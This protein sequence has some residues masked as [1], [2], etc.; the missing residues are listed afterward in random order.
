MSRVAVI[1]N[2]HLGALKRAWDSSA[3]TRNPQFDLVFFGAPRRTALALRAVNDVLATE[4]PSVLRAL[5]L[6]SG[7]TD[8]IIRPADYDLIWL[9][10]LIGLNWAVPQAIRLDMHSR[11]GGARLSSSLLRD[12]FSQQYRESALHYLLQQIRAISSV[13][14]FV[15]PQPFLSEDSPYRKAHRGQTSPLAIQYEDRVRA[16]LEA[17][18]LNYLPQ[19][20]LTVVDRC[21]T[22]ACYSQAGERLVDS[23][24]GGIA[25][26]VR[27]MNAD[28]GRIVINDFMRATRALGS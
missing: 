13:T 23:A 14:V 6:T 2:S 1:G 17:D 7:M 19:N 12:L 16:E 8:P 27:H 22:R 25:D 21:F 28:Y 4:D 18:A 11:S 26:D 9:H 5:T 20:P 10:G 15:S 3:A 24:S